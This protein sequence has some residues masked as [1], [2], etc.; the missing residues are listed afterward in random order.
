MIRINL[1]LKESNLVEFLRDLKD[2]SN[3]NVD[4]IQISIWEN[5]NSH[6]KL[7]KDALDK[8]SFSITVHGRIPNSEQDYEQIFFEDISFAKSIGAKRIILHPLKPYVDFEK[9]KQITQNLDDFV[10]IENVK[11]VSY[12]QIK[13]VRSHFTIDLGNL[14]FN[15]NFSEL[16]DIKNID[17]IHIHNVIGNRDHQNLEKGLLDLKKVIKQFKDSDFTIELNNTFRKWSDL[18]YDYLKAIDFINNYLIYYSSFGK[19]VRLKHLNSFFGNK[20]FNKVI[21]FG[22]KEGYLLHN[23]NAKEKIGVDLNPKRV[24]NDIRYLKRDVVSLKTKDVDL[25]I[26]SEVIEHIQNDLI[27]MKNM[28]DSLKKNG[29]VFLTTINKNTEIDKT[30]KDLERG[31]LRRYGQ[32]LKEKMETIGFTTLDFFAIRSSYYY[33]LKKTK[34][35]KEYEC[36][37][38]KIEGKT[39]ASGIVYIGIKK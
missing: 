2:I 8:Y 16:K 7:I 12:K 15:G 1:G 29:Y 27:V 30:Q 26:S 21:D 33:N 17:E 37:K 10:S 6:V 3:Y 39:F 19:N 35:L 32:D 38:D 9:T 14:Y 28:Y 5:M 20:N 34:S 23:V 25:V 18:K 11:G 31:H 24:F 4:G 36:I 13:E 22:C